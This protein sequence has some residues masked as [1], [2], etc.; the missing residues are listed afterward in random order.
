M[1][2]TVDANLRVRAQNLSKKTLGEIAGD[3]QSVSKAQAEQAKS[4]DLAAKSL[5]SL[6]EQQTR[7]GEISR[8]LEKRK[9]LAATYKEQAAEVQ[10]LAAKVQNLTRIS[11][12]MSSGDKGL[13]G[14]GK[15]DITAINKEIVAT[16]RT[17]DSFTQRAQRTAEALGEVG[18]DAAQ[19]DTAI[20]AMTLVLGKVG[21]AYQTATADVARYNDAVSHT[22]AVQAEAARRTAQESKI[23]GAVNYAAVG[24]TVADKNRSAELAALRQDIE[25]R[26]QQ[27]RSMEIAQ[28]AARRLAAEQQQEISNQPRI[29]QS[30]RE[31]IA[32]QNS[33]VGRQQELNDVFGRQ[34]AQQEREQGVIAASNARRERLIALLN[35]ER[36][37]KILNAEAAREGAKAEED[38][39]NKTNKAAKAQGLFA[40]T[41][42]KSLSVYQRVRG[43]VLGLASAYI[44]VFQAI[45]TVQESIAAVQ[46]NDALNLSLKALNDGSVRAAGKDYEYLRKEADRLGLVFDDIAPKFAN[47][48]AGA[49]AAGLSSQ[50]IRG[51]FTELQRINAG[52][53][54]TKEQADRVNL[55]VSQ[56]F[57]VGRV[58]AEELTGQLAD[59]I[60]AAFVKFAKSLNIS[61]RELTKRLQDGKVSLQDFRTF[62]SSYAAQ[63]N[64]GDITDRLQASINRARNA[65]N[66]W[67]RDLLNANNQ[68]A[69]KNSFKVIE[70]FFSGDQGKKFANDLSQAFGLVVSTLVLL[71]QN[72][73]KVIL[74]FKIF[75]AV[76]AAKAVTDIGLGVASTAA[77]L[78]T[79]AK[80]IAAATVAL[81][82]AEAAS[83]ALTTRTRLLGLAFG[84][85]G[86]AVAAVTAAVTAFS[87]GAIKA[88]QDAAKFIDTLHRVNQ[89]RGTEG[90][91][92]GIG[93]LRAN[94]R[95]TNAELDKLYE[96]QRDFNSLNPFKGIAAVS[97]AASRN[98]LTQ[99]D[100][101]GRIAELKNRQLSD[102]QL[103]EVATKRLAKAK[104]NE[105]AEDAAIALAEQ[106]RI[107][108][109]K[110][111][112]DAADKADA[113]KADEKAAKAAAKAQAKR[114]AAA[115]ARA[116]AERAVADK[117][118]DI[119][120]EIE[121]AKIDTSV[122][123]DAQIEANYAATMNRIK[124]QIEAQR[125]DIAKLAQNSGKAGVDSSSQLTQLDGLLQREQALLEAKA[126]QDKYAA[127]IEIREK[128][129]NDLIAERD[130]KVQLI[131]A[132]QQVGAITT[133]Q[134]WQQ[135]RDATEQY[136]EQIRTQTSLF[137]TFLQG[138][139]PKSGLY[140]KLGVAK[141]I[142]GLQLANVEATKL[143]NIK[144]FTLKYQGQIAEGFGNIFS[145]F[146]EG[147]ADAVQ[148]TGSWSDA[149]KGAWDAFRSFAS[150]FLIQIGKMIA[151]ALILQAIQN[152]INGTSGDYYGAIISAVTGHT[153]G[154]VS[155]RIGNNRSM[156]VNPAVF[157][158]AARFHGGGL[159]GLKSNEV[160]AILKKKEEV[161]SENDPRNV[162][163]GGME[164]G[165]SATPFT[166]INT[167]DAADIVAQGVPA[168]MKTII[169]SMAPYRNQIRQI[170]GVKG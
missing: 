44:G 8:E 55:A 26:S 6:V 116:D 17:L 40:D 61:G 146:A 153:G 79:F 135:T 128:A 169:N 151:Q 48:A 115:R 148:N 3:V 83:V 131:A 152:A 126:Q 72:M 4:S 87:V 43:Q 69:L 91:S 52:L 160:P 140:E 163:N 85:V 70:D 58:R 107:K 11:K 42:R 80:N 124:L 84:P 47:I 39:A 105:A 103:I 64:D 7:L 149:F 82:G 25:L 129:V 138:I 156:D 76:Q 24:Q 110:E 123:T 133:L 167:L 137:L 53:N 20:G 35:T 14:F 111:A 112:Q 22:A 121:K 18:I 159:P 2:K 54:L 45:N 60:P 23:A 142:Q 100:I 120:D 166:I 101:E 57:S 78:V 132:Q 119:Q 127:Q 67:L 164:Q 66:D 139:D 108:A 113:D 71:A 109:A 104:E 90:I 93:D 106:E 98:L 134:A 68:T 155:G 31:Y 89:A 51:T 170:L 161:L 63:F 15:R 162:L 150:D 145:V 5:K 86:I 81:K 13:I 27:A 147:V 118:I 154:V 168:N 41:G 16:Q 158:G 74:V 92:Q 114:D 21:K 34:L 99:T 117:I 73:D 36:G 1:S 102:T 157:S 94:L 130:A 10:N 144:L 49:R 122:K 95:E 97:A 65:Y 125:N 29:N 19:A 143:S 38:L 62:L 37:Q 77:K 59:S 50:D 56:I 30:V 9:S 32:L 88:D 33:R 46:R 12:E 136:N 75:L 28:E 165:G 96:I 141:L